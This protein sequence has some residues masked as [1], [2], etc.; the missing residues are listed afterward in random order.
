MDTQN[1][2]YYKSTNQVSFKCGCSPNPKRVRP[3]KSQLE[4]RKCIGICRTCNI[5]YTLI[6]TKERDKVD[7]DWKD[8][9][10]VREYK[11]KMAKVYRDK[12]KAK[13]E[14]NTVPPPPPPSPEPIETKPKKIQIRLRKNIEIPYEFHYNT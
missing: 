9:D 12:N 13:K 7:L 3:T 8:Q 11:R 1:V 14:L 2:T 5:S 10:T 4:S 6:I